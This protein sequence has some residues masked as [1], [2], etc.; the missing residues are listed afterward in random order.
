MN[1]VLASFAAGL[2]LSSALGGCLRVGPT[3]PAAPPRGAVVIDPAETADCLRPSSGRG[4]LGYAELA[5]PA[6]EPELLAHLAPVPADVRRTAQAAGLEPLL[7]ELLRAQARGDDARSLAMVS[8]RL[9]VV[10]RISSLEI[11]LASLLFEADCTGDQM[12]AVLLE[13]HHRER[14]REL[15]LTIA[16][17]A[18]GALIGVAAGLWDLRGTES[19]GPAALAITGGVATAGLGIPALVPARGR[20]IFPHHRNLFAPIV[21]GQ[22]PDRLYPPFVFRLLTSPPAGG[23]PTPRELLLATWDA[24][25]DDTVPAARRA[26][27]RTLLFGEGGV[28]DGDLVDLRERMYD[29]LESQLSA[30]NRELEVLYL[31][32]DRLLDEPDLPRDP[33]RLGE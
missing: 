8:M 5:G 33:A 11:E 31:F 14:K 22:D 10:M 3:V 24:L 4:G 18:V 7:A 13:L 32:F 25:I 29:A 19:E 27:A 23:G 30:F 9:Q 28:Y 21:A 2:V 1:R 12:E 6:V 16:S 20:V 17:I 15:S 26:T